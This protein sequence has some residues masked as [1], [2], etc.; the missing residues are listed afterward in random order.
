M[1][2]LSKAPKLERLLKEFD[3]R[4]ATCVEASGLLF[5]SGVP[6][7]NL[8]TGKKTVGPI[9]LHAHDALDCYQY[10]LECLGL[11]LDHVVKVNAFLRNPVEDYPQWNEVFQSRF[12]APY[13]CRTTVGSP[14]VDGELEL[15]IIASRTSRADAEIVEAL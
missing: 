15:E 3:V 12:N 10:I 14:L 13:P 9:S 5:F 11:S 6:G 2:I 7:L 1:K 4:N 8:E